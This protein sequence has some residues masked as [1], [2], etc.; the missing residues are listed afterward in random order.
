MLQCCGVFEW[1]RGAKKRGS[2]NFDAEMMVAESVAAEKLR[3]SL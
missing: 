3:K 2:R 1:V